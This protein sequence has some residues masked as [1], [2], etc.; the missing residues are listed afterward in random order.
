MNGNSLK[1]AA[2]VRPK[3]ASP[4][5]QWSK[6]VW[7]LS[8]EEFGNIL[9]FIHMNANFAETD[10]LICFYP[11]PSPT[12]NLCDNQLCGEF[13]PLNRDTRLLS[14]F[15]LQQSLRQSTPRR[16]STVK[17]RHPNAVHMDAHL[18]KAG[19]EIIR[20]IMA[21]QCFHHQITLVD[22]STWKFKFQSF[23]GTYK[24]TFT[25]ISLHQHR[26]AKS[27]IHLPTVRAFNTP[28]KSQISQIVAL[29]CCTL[30]TTD[31]NPTQA[32]ERRLPTSPLAVR[33]HTVATE[34]HQKSGIKLQ[35]MECLCEV[36]KPK[37][38]ALCDDVESI[39]DIHEFF[40][41]R[42]S[43]PS[44]SLFSS[45][46]NWDLARNNVDTI[47]NLAPTLSPPPPERG[48]TSEVTGAIVEFV[49]TQVWDAITGITRGIFNVV[50]RE[51]TRFSNA[52]AP[53]PTVKRRRWYVV[54]A[55]TVPGVYDDLALATKNAVGIPGGLYKRFTLEA[56]ARAA[57]EYASANDAVVVIPP[58]VER[59]PPP[60]PPPS[61]TD[62][63]GDD[64]PQSD[65]PIQ[66]TNSSPALST[67]FQDAPA[68]PAS[69]MFASCPDGITEPI[70][71]ESEEDSEEE[72]EESES[73]PSIRSDV[74]FYFEGGRFHTL[75]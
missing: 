56:D 64:G 74:D 14:T 5:P 68:S 21:D 52:R 67:L 73:V 62:D 25:P 10:L 20:E 50:N 13:P 66:P 12:D 69:S 63:E 60:P 36:I 57:F 33:V 54:T 47:C 1:Y 29:M 3:K 31:P 38:F 35:D 58:R 19:I 4:E 59:K 15:P 65:T 2:L 53:I 11:L 7:P 72:Y 55:G 42:V 17:L 26:I 51:Y 40:V 43:L 37:Y 34:T 27:A 49:V 28:V 23:L 39:G 24:N 6:G 18:I 46:V 61:V 71:I 30:P 70:E 9:E 75:H 41:R 48:F 8:N 32:T 45:G 22:Q 44:P 16:I